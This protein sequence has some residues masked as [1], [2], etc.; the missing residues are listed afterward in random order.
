MTESVLLSLAM[1]R[2][3]AAR[4]G[5]P[6]PDKAAAVAMAE[7]R[8][9]PQARLVVT[10]DQAAAY[11]ASHAAGPRHAQER[12]F[13]LWQVNTLAHP[14]YDETKLLDPDY[15]ADAALA[16]SSHGTNWHPWATFSSG[17]YLAFMPAVTEAPTASEKPT[18]PDVSTAGI[19]ASREELLADGTELAEGPES[20]PPPEPSDVG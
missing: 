11:N 20:T 3:L 1:L 5:F 14:Q 15:N 12:S 6:D 4:H 2:D 8:G 18:L 17:A 10:P 16:I 7:S 19:Q 9:N 13:G